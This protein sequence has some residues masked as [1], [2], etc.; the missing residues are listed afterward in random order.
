MGESTDTISRTPSP[1]WTIAAAVVGVLGAIAMVAGVIYQL[2]RSQPVGEGELFFQEASTAASQ[3]DE[4][5]ASSMT[6]DA[7]IRHLRNQMDVEAAAIVDQ[8][9]TIIAST[10]DNLVGTTMNEGI[11]Q[12]G[13]SDRKFAAVAT[14]L[15]TPITIDGIEEWHE[16]DVLYRVIQPLEGS[17]SGLLLYYDISGLLSRRAREQGIRPQTLQMVGVGAVLIAIAGLLLLGRARAIR[18]FREMGL[19][20]EFLRRRSD[21]LEEHND[22]LREARAQAER[23][24][25]LAEETNRIRAEFVLMINHELRTPLTSVVTGT[26]LL[27]M[28]SILDSK[29]RQDLLDE[30]VVDGHRLQEMIAQMLTVA[31]IE[32]R[33]LSYSLR[34][35]PLVEVLAVIAEKHPSLPLR[36]DDEFMAPRVRLRTDPDTLAQLVSSLADNAVTHGAARVVIICSER[37]PFSPMLQVGEPPQDATYFLIC[38]DGPGIDPGFLPRAFEKFEKHSRSSGTGL[39]LYVA[40]MMIQAMGGSIAVST[41]PHGTIMAVAVATVPAQVPAGVAV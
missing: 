9:A 23:A 16:G 22:S 1:T 33:G 29:E 11:L 28:N 3:V 36:L 20:A 10:S 38:D 32:N 31:R 41:S 34:E 39:G 37:L 2:E 21:E 6:L 5:I 35:V 13:L 30:M 4:M 14:P 18:H 26:E 12:Y 24:L 17:G 27:R 19:E 7:T 40:K 8:D 25:A 15:P